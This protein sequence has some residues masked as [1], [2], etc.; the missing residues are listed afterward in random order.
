MIKRSYNSIRARLRTRY[1]RHLPWALRTSPSICAET[2]LCRCEER[3]YISSSYRLCTSPSVQ[4]EKKQLSAKL[5]AATPLSTFHIRPI[6]LRAVG[7]EAGTRMR[8]AVGYNFWGA[9]ST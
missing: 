3:S 8:Y 7:G 4:P 2:M 6:D 1:E 5:L 9:R